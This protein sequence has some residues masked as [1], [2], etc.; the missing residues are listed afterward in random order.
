[1]CLARHGTNQQ[2]QPA[3]ADGSRVSNAATHGLLF[4]L[5]PLLL[6][7]FKGTSNQACGKRLRQ[8]TAERTQQN[9]EKRQF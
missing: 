8:A 4:L 5:L 9:V 2:Q 6:C 1:M 3:S 7:V